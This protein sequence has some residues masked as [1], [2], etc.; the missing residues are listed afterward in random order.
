MEFT[1]VKLAL[2]YCEMDFTHINLALHY[3]EI[4]LSGKHV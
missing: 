2:R 3:C 1:P 4:L